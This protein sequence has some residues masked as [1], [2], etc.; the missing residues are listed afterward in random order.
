LDACLTQISRF[1]P[2]INAI[3]AM[4]IESAIAC[5][6]AATQRWQDGCPMGPLDGLPIGVKDLQNTKGL[7]TTHGSIRARGYIPESDMPMVARLRAAGAII[8]AKTNVPEMGAGGNSRN[9]VW[10]ATGNPFG[11]NLIAGGS[12]GGSA[13]ALAANFLPLC[14]GSDT[15]GSLRMLELRRCE[16]VR[17]DRGT[18]RSAILCSAASVIIVSVFHSRTS[19]TGWRT[20]KGQSLGIE[21]SPVAPDHVDDQSLARRCRQI[22]ANNGG[23]EH[24]DDAGRRL[25][26]LT[27]TARLDAKS[28]TATAAERQNG[29]RACLAHQ[30]NAAGKGKHGRAVHDAGAK[31][32][33]PCKG[34]DLTRWH[35]HPSVGK[36]SAKQATDG[37][38]KPV[39]DSAA[40]RATSA[41]STKERV[42]NRFEG[43]VDQ[44]IGQVLCDSGPRC[45]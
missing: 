2:K 27:F 35:E 36:A 11:A 1:N 4:D 42:L 33:A 5:A 10:G 32:T 25:R 13:A 34:C 20:G 3:A 26:G 39:E 23:I 31:N 9:R 41:E 38:G 24:I 12:S 6:T 22:I 40:S 16:T 44:P 28:T 7:L 21:A 37:L 8:L 30:S 15:G 17:I 19:V 14:T 45:V 29:F 43:V 18:V